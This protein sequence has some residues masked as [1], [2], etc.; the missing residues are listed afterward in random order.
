MTDGKRSIDDK[1]KQQQKKQTP[2]ASVELAKRQQQMQAQLN[3]IGR[4]M[5]QK[6]SNWSS[7][8]I[9][10]LGLFA[11]CLTIAAV[12]SRQSKSATLSATL[13]AM[14]RQ[15]IGDVVTIE[16]INRAEIQAHLMRIATVD[17]QL[18]TIEN[19]AGLLVSTTTEL[20][21]N[22]TGKR[23]ASDEAFVERFKVLK[24]QASLLEDASLAPFRTRLKSF[25]APLREALANA[26]RFNPKEASTDRLAELEKEVF[27]YRERFGDVLE[28]L[29]SVLAAAQDLSSGAFKRPPMGAFAQPPT[30]QAF[31][32]APG[33][34]ASHLRD[35]V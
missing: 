29:N 12:V 10:A 13:N 19:E 4:R 1:K 14:E 25:E 11:G 23:I 27:A 33:P 21:H 30:P 16:S 15:A 2:S 22:E 28:D 7:V 17:A 24:R 20:L 35:L 32:F 34:Y 5:D 6:K 3:A 8:L 31:L 9:I 26:T 18:N